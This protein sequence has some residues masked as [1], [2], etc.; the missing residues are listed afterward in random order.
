M[1]KP[2]ARKII[3]GGK[4]P[5]VIYIG[6]PVTTAGRM[7]QAWNRYLNEVGESV[8]EDLRNPKKSKESQEEQTPE[9]EKLSNEP[10]QISKIK[11]DGAE[12]GS[13]LGSGDLLDIGIKKIIRSFSIAAKTRKA[14]KDAGGNPKSLRRT[15]FF[16]K[17]LGSEFGGDF[18]R[19]T[20]GTFS[21]KPDI[22]QD[23]ALSKE[24]RFTEIINRDLAARP[25][26]IKQPEFFDTGKYEDKGLAKTF[27]DLSQK[28]ADKILGIESGFVRLER[29]QKE[30]SKSFENISKNFSKVGD[31]YVKTSTNLKNFIENKEKILAIKQKLTS[32][33]YKQQEK[34]QFA[35]SEK[36]AEQLNMFGAGVTDVKEVDQTFAKKSDE[37]L[38]SIFGEYFL[39][40]TADAGRRGVSRWF[41]RKALQLGGRKLARSGIVSGAETLIGGAKSLFTRATS[42]ISTKAVTGFLR[43]ILKRVPVVGGLIDFVVSLA[44]G[45]PVGRAAAKAVGATLGAGLGTLIPIPGVG[46]IAGGILGDLVGGAIYD[47]VVGG[48]S[49]SKDNAKQPEQKLSQGGIKT[50]VAGEAGNEI[51]QPL[52]SSFGRDVLRG[53]KAGSSFLPV[54]GPVLSATAG[55]VRSPMYNEVLGPVVNP[56][57]EPLLSQYK[58]PVYSGDIGS[59]KTSMVKSAETQGKAKSEKAKKNPLQAIKD[60][61]GSAVSGIGNF[62]GSIFSG[63]GGFVG[64]IGNFF[65]NLFTGGGG[66]QAGPLS[67]GGGPGAT[68]ANAVYNY[69]ISKNISDFHAKGI[70]ANISRESSFRMDPAGYFI[71]MFQWDPINRGPR[72]AAAVPDWRTNWKGQVDYALGEDYGPSYLSKT[73]SSAG[74][75]AYD[76]MVNWERPAAWVRAKYTADEYERLIQGLNLSQSDRQQDN[77]DAPRVRAPAAPAESPESMMNGLLDALRRPEP[78]SASPS[79]SA[80]QPLAMSPQLDA[81]TGASGIHHPSTVVINM[82][83][84]GKDTVAQNSSGGMFIPP[85]NQSD[86]LDVAFL[87]LLSLSDA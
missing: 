6:K 76:F 87:H 68:S 85:S 13:T 4:L 14:Y 42:G 28:T 23:P 39:P 63:I 50:T 44:L 35:Q 31:V 80:S 3:Y 52:T 86:G 19:R 70:V 66:G 43:P 83:S 16:G 48:S 56:I 73:F 22:T 21:S 74:E 46:T 71:G 33:L 65:N 11:F 82:P 29:S 55:I 41:R 64:G 27:L 72:M 49:G 81:A 61:F 7:S 32:F 57:L 20:R 45:E 78:V 1:T 60:F 40:G 51:Y 37:E 62:F 59:V 77:N 58:V 10:I 53:M 67:A 26:M 34:E 54:I 30:T 8:L 38:E 75:A 18:L 12:T 25:T 79:S 2:R 47:A 24:Q 15:Y 17:A 5:G 69:L 36:L 84:S 9:I